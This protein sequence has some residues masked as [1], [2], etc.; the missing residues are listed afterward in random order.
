MHLEWFVCASRVGYNDGLEDTSTSIFRQKSHDRQAYVHSR[1]ALICVKMILKKVTVYISTRLFRWRHG[2]VD[3]VVFDSAIIVQSK[4]DL[5]CVYEFVARIMFVRQI[6]TRMYENSHK[7]FISWITTIFCIVS[8]YF[9][10]IFVLK[11]SLNRRFCVIE[12]I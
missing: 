1:I 9:A 12:L 3:D 2:D 5:V 6:S 11:A 8:L 4:Y 10:C 7:Y